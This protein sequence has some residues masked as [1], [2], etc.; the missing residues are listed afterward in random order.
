MLKIMWKKYA[1]EC[2]LSNR[3]AFCEMKKLKRLELPEEKDATPNANSI[4]P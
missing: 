1:N 4:F 3:H 2:F